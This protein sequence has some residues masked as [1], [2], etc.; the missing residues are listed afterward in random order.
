LRKS[1]VATIYTRGFGQQVSGE[2]WDGLTQFWR[3]QRNENV[4]IK[5]IAT[6]FFEKHDTELA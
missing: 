1:L 3:G 6:I 2:I 5:E 4:I